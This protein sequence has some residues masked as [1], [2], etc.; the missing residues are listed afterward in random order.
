MALCTTNDSL[1]TF[2]PI[3]CSTTVFVVDFSKMRPITIRCSSMLIYES[4]FLLNFA[5]SHIF[6]LI[7]YFVF[8]DLYIAAILRAWFD[9]SVCVSRIAL[10]SSVWQTVAFMICQCKRLMQF[11]PQKIVASLYINN[12]CWYV[13][14]E[15]FSTPERKN[16][17]ILEL[18]IMYLKDMN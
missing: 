6:L 2:L 10:I 14:W 7:I 9:L 13:V 11:C 12:I 18:L 16:M 5:S 8:V 17:I 4:R 1:T 15:Q 3:L